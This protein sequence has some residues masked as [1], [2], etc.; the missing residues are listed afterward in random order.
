M[1]HGSLNPQ[2]H[3]AALPHLRRFEMPDM[4]QSGGCPQEA[5]GTGWDT[6]ADCELRRTH[7][8]EDLAW[9]GAQ[10]NKNHEWIPALICKTKSR[11]EIPIISVLCLCW[12][13]CITE[14]FT[15]WQ[16]DRNMVGHRWSSCQSSPCKFSN[17]TFGPEHK[18]H[19]VHTFCNNFVFCWLKIMQCTNLVS[20]HH[21]ICWCYIICYC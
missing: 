12:L 7:W 16:F 2:P 4:A 5:L 19:Q 3:P 10:K 14:Y 8:T 17:W 9:P 13:L 15:A 1:R 18:M 20:I 11:L 21:L 6:V